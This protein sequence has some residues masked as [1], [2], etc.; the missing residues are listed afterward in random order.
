MKSLLLTLLCMLLLAEPRGGLALPEPT[1]ESSDLLAPGPAAETNQQTRALAEDELRQMLRTTL[2]ANYVGEKGELELRFTRPW[3][4]LTVP[5]EPLTLKVL[6]LPTLGV[7]PNFIVRF[8]I[9]TVNASLGTWQMPAQARIFRDVWVAQSPLTRGLLIAKADLKRERRDVLVL[10]EACWEGTE[11]EEATN[12]LAVNLPTGAPLYASSVKPRT[13]IRRGQLAE[14]LFQ[15]G[16]LL[17]SLEVEVLEDGA[18]GQ[19]VRVRNPRS[20]TIFPGKVQN[21]Q[22]I[23]VA[24]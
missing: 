3:R 22:T 24:F 16:A 11:A 19:T 10:R 20:R 8:E 23:L 18:S 6:E 17:V 2:Q 5:N 13:L 1:S 12:E 14:A 7:S 21:E 9:R 15:D 4:P